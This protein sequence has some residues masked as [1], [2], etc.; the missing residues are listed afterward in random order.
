[1][2]LQIIPGGKGNPGR[3]ACPFCGEKFEHRYI[4]SSGI[5]S[6]EEHFKKNKTCG[7]NKMANNPTTD[8]YATFEDWGIEVPGPRLV[9]PPQGDERSGE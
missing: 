6:L 1:M 8:K 7:R 3:Y 4:D 5:V 2:P 9:T